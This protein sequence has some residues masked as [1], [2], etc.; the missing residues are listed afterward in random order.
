M[1][2]FGMNDQ[3]TYTA[4]R[5][6]STVADVV[7]REQQADMQA[8]Q[9]EQRAEQ[10]DL[11][12]EE[13]KLKAQQKQ[14]QINSQLADLMASQEAAFSNSGVSVSS[15]TARNE[16]RKA[17]EEAGESRASVENNRRR[18]EMALEQKKIGLLERADQTE[19][20]A[21][22]DMGQSL[23]NFALRNA[24]IAADRERRKERRGTV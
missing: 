14:D 5:G 9:F 4:L 12:A 22:M 23:A 8:Q 20:M 24:S 21:R 7:N 11:E 15:G 10:M 3:T 18:Q 13:L 19:E 16:F 2:L 1:S 6:I 17:Q